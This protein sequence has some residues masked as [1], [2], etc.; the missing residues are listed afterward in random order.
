MSAPVTFLPKDTKEKCLRCKDA[1][2]VL[3]SRKETFCADCFVFFLRGKQRKLMLDEC[4]KVKYG[5]VAERSGVQR[6]LL[7]L[8]YGACSLVLLDMVA[9]LLL[10]QN[11]AHGGR[12][13]F[14][15]AVL[16]IRE[17]RG[18]PLRG[19]KVC[20][21]SMCHFGPLVAKYSP[22]RI[23][24]HE[25]DLKTAT[26]DEPVITSVR[27]HFEVLARP[28]DSP[29]TVA[30]LL[31]LCASRSLQED[32]LDV[33]KNELVQQY[34]AKTGCQTVIYGHSMTLLAEKVIA[35]T[36]KG[37]G[38]TIH[39][40]V[41]NRTVNCDGRTL[42][43]IYPFREI[44][45]AELVAVLLFDAHLKGHLAHEDASGTRLAKD[46]TVR[47]LITQYFDALDASGYAS[48]ASTVVKT[49]EKL[50]GPKE[51]VLGECEVCGCGIHHA[52]QK[53]L[54]DITV[55]TPAPLVTEEE[56]LYAREYA[57]SES[58]ASGRVFVLCYGCTATFAASGEGFMWATRATTKEIIDEYVLTDEGESKE[59]L[60]N[61]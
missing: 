24:Y 34:A 39:S 43:I 58:L 26:I 19:L 17:R 10:E 61:V 52:P 54:K 56:R 59:E 53:W 13:G 25:I 2:A 37:R 57:V 22:V 42:R 45:K 11:L 5:A 6:V 49:A 41:T 47:E 21:D 51:P 16:H 12:Q 32:L 8:S 55:A 1:L 28:H 40:S 46:M 15:L 60:A 35:L 31:E 7:P 27:N 38:L 50:A 33:L 4:Y 30:D 48:T 44:L 14:E 36:V 20:R 18:T 29:K 23:V 9:S 3:R